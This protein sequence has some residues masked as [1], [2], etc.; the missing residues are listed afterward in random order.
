MRTRKQKK[1]INK[2]TQKKSKR[3]SVKPACKLIHK[4]SKAQSLYI[5]QKK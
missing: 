1:R 3:I 4:I 2:R 5:P